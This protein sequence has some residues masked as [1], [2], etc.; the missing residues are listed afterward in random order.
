VPP[1]E[2]ELEE[3]LLELEERIRS[4]LVRA[5]GHTASNIEILVSVSHEGGRPA[6]LVVDVRASKRGARDLGPLVEA[7]IE[8]AVREFERRLGLRPRKAK[9][10]GV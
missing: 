6:R 4:I 3:A 8:E 7:A 10:A 1:R 2:E 5:L 9:G